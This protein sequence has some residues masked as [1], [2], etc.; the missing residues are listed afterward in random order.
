VPATDPRK[1]APVEPV[2]LPARLSQTLLRHFD[3]CARSGYLYMKHG[4]GVP[5]PAMA[6]GTAFHL[7]AERAT[8]LLV[9]ESEPRLPYDVG[10]GLMVEVFGEVDVPVAEHDRLRQMAYHWCEGFAIDPDKVVAVEQ[11]MVLDIGGWTVSGKVDYAELAD[12]LCAVRDYK[13][14]FNLPAVGDVAVDVGDGRLAP[15]AFQLVL[16]VLL[17]AFGRPVRDGGEVDPFPLA[18]AAEAFD[19]SEVYPAYLHDDGLPMRG[20]VV[21]K[22]ELADHLASVEALVARFARAAGAWEFSA[23]DGPHCVEC[24]ARRECPLPEHLRDFRGRIN[25]PDELSEAARLHFK[26]KDELAADWR[27]IRATAGVLAPVPLG[28]GFEL[29]FVSEEKRTVDRDGMAAAAVEAA[30]YGTPFDPD[31]FVKVTT[32]TPLKRRRSE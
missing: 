9:E 27:E 31:D 12:G 4:G 30:A 14:T 24:P 22:A 19:A 15:R 8:R 21:V 16:Y 11:K 10:R 20:G 32:S 29:A 25:T 5:S 1:L 2:D 7:F 17:L 26:R 28:D 13:T 3:R 18:G 23:M 6:R